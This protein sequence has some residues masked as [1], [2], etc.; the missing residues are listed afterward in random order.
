[1]SKNTIPNIWTAQ[2]KV[3]HLYK[4]LSLGLGGFALLMTII[5]MVQ[6]FRNPIVV[7]RSGDMQEFYPSERKRASLEKA[8]VEAFTKQFLANLYVWKEFNANGTARDITPFAESGLIAK[9]TDGLNQKYNKELKGK[10]LSQAITF[11]A[12]DVQDSQVVAH[13]DRILKIEGIPLIIPTEVRLS[14]VQGDPTRLN[15]MGVYVSGITELDG[16]K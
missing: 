1:M 6:A 8:D 9:V 12:V 11:V 13:F 4:M 3:T 5:S 2:E 10:R 14:M 15:P 7:V 16:A